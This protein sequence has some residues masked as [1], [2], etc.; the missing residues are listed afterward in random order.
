M[1]HPHTK[2]QWIND[3]IGYGVF[4]TTFIPQGT[5]VYVRDALEIVVNQ[6]QFLLLSE[7]LQRDVDKYS[8]TDEHGCRVMSWDRAKYINHSCE[9]NTMSTGYS[10]E[11]ALRDIQAGDQIT[12][13]YGLFNIPYPVDINCG[14][15][16]CRR[17]LL[18]NDIE[19]YA[20]QW[21]AQ[22]RPVLDSMSFDDQPLWEFV[23]E[24]TKRALLGYLTGIAEYRSL[25]GLKYHFP[26]R[27]NGVAV[28]AL[29]GH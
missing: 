13:E 4:A 22:V 19:T 8:Y 23:D 7:P 24:E 10:F 16:N 17:Q 18:P 12:D 6:E 11:I 28:G 5:I 21:D 3:E 1:I 9:C 25:R 27:L 15:V 20:A 2:V 14:C 26:Q 29:N